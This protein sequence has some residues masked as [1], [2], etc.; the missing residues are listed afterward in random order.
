M[1]SNLTIGIPCYNCLKTVEKTLQSIN[2]Q[3][4]Q[5]YE[6]IFCDDASTQDYSKLLK[7]FSS[8]NIRYVRMDKN[9]GVGAVRARIVDEAKTKFLTMIDS[10]DTFYSVDVIEFFH[11]EISLRDFDM[12]ITNFIQELPDNENIIFGTPFIGCHGKIY[13]LDFLKRQNINFPPL[14]AHEE[15]FVNRSIALHGN[16]LKNEKVTYF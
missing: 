11:E 9:S 15:G 5:P 12:L 13:N 6:I 16:V 2:I 4:E 10:D 3:N 14:R 7:Q 8:L 1:K